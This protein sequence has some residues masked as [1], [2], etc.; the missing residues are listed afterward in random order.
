MYVST[1]QIYTFF[2][3]APKKAVFIYGNPPK[4]AGQCTQMKGTDKEADPEKATNPDDVVKE[5][6][7]DALTL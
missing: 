2:L 5:F 4:S 7:F 6:A 1:R 3:Y